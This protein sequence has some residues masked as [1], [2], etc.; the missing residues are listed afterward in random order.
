M[1]K[2]IDGDREAKF[3]LNR[4]TLCAT[5]SRPHST[6][7]LSKL[8]RIN[9]QGLSVPLRHAGRWL[10]LR[11]FSRPKLREGYTIFWSV[12]ATVPLH[13]RL[14]VLTQI[15]AALAALHAR[16]QDTSGTAAYVALRGPPLSQMTQAEV[17]IMLHLGTSALF[18][19]ALRRR[20]PGRH[21]Q[22][23]PVSRAG[24]DAIVRRASFAIL[25]SR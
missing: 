24:P 3:S 6:T 17:E 15:D 9:L 12:V 25:H 8:K 13:C 4:I 18:V 10:L 7:P 14:A 19:R 11:I 1:V 22:G 23:R 2:T 16:S 21:R 5:T 20:H